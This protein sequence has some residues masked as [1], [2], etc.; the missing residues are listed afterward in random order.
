M[1]LPDV[2]LEILALFQHTNA[3]S[4]VLQ[5]RRSGTLLHT[6]TAFLFSKLILLDESRNLPTVDPVLSTSRTN[7]NIGHSNNTSTLS[8]F[9]HYVRDRL[10]VTVIFSSLGMAFLSR[11]SPALRFPFDSNVS[12]CSQPHCKYKSDTELCGHSRVFVLRF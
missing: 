7:R 1:E 3:G 9:S 6:F 2:Q 12:P 8:C 11:H 5:I 4:L 10:Y